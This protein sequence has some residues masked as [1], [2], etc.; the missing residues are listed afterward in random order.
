LTQLSVPKNQ[1]L[2]VEDSRDWQDI[3]NQSIPRLIS[4]TACNFSAEILQAFSMGDA[5]EKFSQATSNDTLQIIVLD[6]SFPG[7]DGAAF[8]QHAVRAGFS[9]TII[10][11]SGN[12]YGCQSIVSAA[13]EAA[14]NLSNATTGLTLLTTEGEKSK[15]PEL[16]IQALQDIHR[17]S[18]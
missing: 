12:V 9:G 17:Q 18:K 4:R 6:Y 5:N 14:S 10:A 7:G 3:W 2:L 1:I 15:V 8:A 13:N 16:V 11:A